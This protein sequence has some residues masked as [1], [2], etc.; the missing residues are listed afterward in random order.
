SNMKDLFVRVPWWKMKKRPV[1]IGD[2]NPVR[3]ATEQE[4]FAE[5]A[6][7]HGRDPMA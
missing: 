1:M 2:S 3:Q 4:S 7:E 6:G 5:Q